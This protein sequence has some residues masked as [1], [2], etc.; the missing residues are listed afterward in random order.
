MEKQN[1]QIEFVAAASVAASSATARG[2]KG[3]AAAF[4]GAIEAMS[5][6]Q[7]ALDRPSERPTER[8][9]LKRDDG[10]HLV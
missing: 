7:T 2:R 10:A 5:M 6:V 3:N 9:G 4:H 8:K 1:K